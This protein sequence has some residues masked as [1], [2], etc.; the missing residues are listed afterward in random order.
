MGSSGISLI[1]ETVVY[2]LLHTFGHRCCSLLGFSASQ[3]LLLCRCWVVSDPSW[4]YGLVAHQVPLSMGFPD[5]NTGVGFHFL[6]QAIFLTQ[7]SNPHLLHW[8]VDSLPLSH[9]GSPSLPI[10]ISKYHDRDR[11]ESG[12]L[13]QS[14]HLL[15]GMSGPQ[16]AVVLEVWCLQIDLKTS[17]SLLLIVFSGRMNLSKQGC[18]GWNGKFYHLPFTFFRL[19]CWEGIDFCLVRFLFFFMVSGFAIMLQMLF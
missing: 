6:P 15:S 4:P 11:Y 2:R 9:Q 10:W 8:Q 1:P 12:S 14:F 18:H 16:V 3:L 19:F 7:G 5:K 13:S 17:Y